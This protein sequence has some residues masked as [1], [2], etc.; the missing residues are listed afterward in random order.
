MEQGVL[1]HFTDRRSPWQNGM[2]ERAG[3]LWKEKLEQVIATATISGTEEYRTAAAHTVASR[4][5]HFN[6][7]GFSLDQRTFA[8]SLRL[9]AHTLASDV[10]QADMLVAQAS[11]QVQ[12]DWEIR[13]AAAEAWVRHRDQRAAAKAWHAERGG[14]RTAS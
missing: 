4:S 7:S 2:M 3:W 6:R 5:R 9:P 13:S 11:D 10:I 14:T 12:R 1:I 8:S